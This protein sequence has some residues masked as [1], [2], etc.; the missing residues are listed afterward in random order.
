MTRMECDFGPQSAFRRHQRRGDLLDVILD[1][2]G[3]A[4]FGLCG[5]LAEFFL[6]KTLAQ[7]IPKLPLDA[8]RFGTVLFVGRFAT[9]SL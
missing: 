9:S 1:D 7:Q 3:L 4:Q 6:S 2:A 5:M 8:N